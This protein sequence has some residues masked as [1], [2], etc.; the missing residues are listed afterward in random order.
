MNGLRALGFTPE[1]TLS[2]E[3]LLWLSRRVRKESNF[4]GWVYKPW[5]S[6]DK[7]MS[8]FCS[9]KF[10]KFGWFISVIAATGA[11]RAVIIVPENAFNEG[12][13]TLV[14]KL[15]SFVNRG[16]SFSAFLS[17]LLIRRSK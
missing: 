15:E 3:A 5:R 6:R 1:M 4:K 8:L 17:V 9:M 12:W 13:L 14:S 11:S 10:N 7:D 2:N 16:T